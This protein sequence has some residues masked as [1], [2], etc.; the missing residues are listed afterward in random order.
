MTV[1]N[2]KT[3]KP[4]FIF[5]LI[6]ILLPF[7]IKFYIEFRPLPLSDAREPI[8]YFVKSFKMSIAHVNLEQSSEKPY[9]IKYDAFINVRSAKNDLDL[10]AGSI[11][12][13]AFYNCSSDSHSFE[14]FLYFNYND[15]TDTSYE[16][17]K[18]FNV[19]FDEIKLKYSNL[20]KNE[21][22][23]S[24]IYDEICPIFSEH[25]V[26]SVFLSN[27]NVNGGEAIQPKTGRVGVRWELVKEGIRIVDTLKNSP[28][29]LIGLNAGDIIL[30]ING[31]NVQSND[32][33]TKEIFK[34]ASL[35]NGDAG[36]TAALKI[37]KNNSKDILDVS[38]VRDEAIEIKYFI[39]LADRKIDLYNKD[40]SEI[41]IAC[42]PAKPF[43]YHRVFNNLSKPIVI[44]V[45]YPIK[46][47]GSIS[48]E[49][50]LGF[51]F[52]D[53]QY[54]LFYKNNF[55]Q[56]LPKC[57][58]VRMPKLVKPK[59]IFFSQVLVFY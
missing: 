44:T 38:L 47:E 13:R 42:E 5:G 45:G 26:P 14:K 21:N 55:I 15:F 51:P 41:E 18:F 46:G 43:P 8:K 2:S 28:A 6:L 48:D 11:K 7:A 30:E 4:L 58:V 9:L 27:S 29:D 32:F 39:N 3:I 52:K 12:A 59:K 37:L 23:F 54:E 33:T 35:L 57:Q 40:D 19:N 53:N 50:Y 31:T 16:K 24:S 49:P 10:P 25:V 34:F 56:S 17:T 36:S 1:K 20:M 22:I